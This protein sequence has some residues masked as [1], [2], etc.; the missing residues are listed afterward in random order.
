MGWVKFEKELGAYNWAWLDEIIFD[1][2]AQG[3][4]PWIDFFYGNPAYP[5][6][7]GFTLKNKNHPTSEEA[8]KAWGNYIRSIVPRYKDYVDECENWN[9]PN[10]RINPE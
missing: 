3:V 5:D 8:L 7:G 1:M 10:N 6:G 2:V 4:E 9:E